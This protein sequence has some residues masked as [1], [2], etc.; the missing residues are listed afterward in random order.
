MLKMYLA[1][2]QNLTSYISLSFTFKFLSART[3]HRFES[4]FL[5]FYHFPVGLLNSRVN[6]KGSNRVEGNDRR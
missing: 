1:E 6:R 2:V 4:H 3:N 5:K